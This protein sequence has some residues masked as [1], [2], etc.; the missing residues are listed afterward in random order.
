MSLK[1]TL[2]VFTVIFL[3]R[4]LFALESVI[5]DIIQ[6]NDGLVGVLDNQELAVLLLHDQIHDTS[7]HTP[8]I[9]H[10][11]IDL[12]GKLGGFE[13]LRPQNDVSRRI[14]DIVSGNIPV[15]NS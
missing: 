7:N 13:V 9:I 14:F 15:K 8:T 2:K 10:G 11:Q 3:I 4:V 6:S 1:S 5:G 12:S